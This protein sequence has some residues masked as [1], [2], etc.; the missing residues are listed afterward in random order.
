MVRFVTA[1]PMG[2]YRSSRAGRG[3]QSQKRTALSGGN[4]ESIHANPLTDGAQGSENV[5]H[6]CVN[7]STHNAK[8]Y[9]DT[10]I[11]GDP[12]E[13]TNSPVPL[14]LADGDI[15]DWTVPWN[16]RTAMSAARG[17]ASR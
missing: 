4:G 12:V 13:V 8:Q 16:Q 6:G 17:P 7:L 14:T 1:V 2:V 10:A 15:A 5:T 11:F 3:S 9:F